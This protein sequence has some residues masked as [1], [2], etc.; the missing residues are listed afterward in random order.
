MRKERS[1]GHAGIAEKTINPVEKSA[2][3]L[4]VDA[5]C[6]IALGKAC[7]KAVICLPLEWNP[8]ICTENTEVSPVY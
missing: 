2:K 7:P 6:Q 1:I 5:R 3:P 4:G 8:S